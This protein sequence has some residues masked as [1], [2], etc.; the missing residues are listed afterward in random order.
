[1]KNKLKKEFDNISETQS[2]QINKSGTHGSLAP[3]KDISI[4]EA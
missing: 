1:M 2:I 4:F 3:M